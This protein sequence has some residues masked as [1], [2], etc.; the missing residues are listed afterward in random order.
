MINLLRDPL[1]MIPSDN[2]SISLN[3]SQVS[4]V[5]N[6]NP[7]VL[8]FQGV[9]LLLQLLQLSLLGQKLEEN[10][11]DIIKVKTFDFTIDL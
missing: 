10:E 11:L 4:T 5:V 9:V 8:H 7:L 1:W 3:L 2:S 6:L